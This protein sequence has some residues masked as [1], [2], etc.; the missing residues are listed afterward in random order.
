MYGEEATNGVIEIT[1]RRN[2]IDLTR[3]GYELTIDQSVYSTSMSSRPD[4][5][6]QFGM[7]FNG[8]YGPFLVPGEPLL[9]AGILQIFHPILMDWIT[10][11]LY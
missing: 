9:I 2:A 1:T 11:V 8:Q 5:Q 7:G 6:N 4:Y 10:M 3:E